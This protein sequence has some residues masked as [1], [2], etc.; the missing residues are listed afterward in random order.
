MFHESRSIGVVVCFLV[1]LKFVD[2]LFFYVLHIL[3]LQFIVF[4][5]MLHVRNRRKYTTSRPR[6]SSR[7]FYVVYIDFS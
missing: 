2:Y 4:S 3:F 6:T 7:N 1:F 5:G